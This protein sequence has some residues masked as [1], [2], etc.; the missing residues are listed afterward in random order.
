MIVPSCQAHKIHDYKIHETSFNSLRLIS[1]QGEYGSLSYSYDAVGNRT[2][3]SALTF[4]YNS[5]N[6]LF[7]I[8]DGMVFAYDENENIVTKSNGT[9]TWEYIY[10]TRNGLVKTQKNL[11]LAN[12]CFNSIVLQWLHLYAS[13]YY[14]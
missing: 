12:Q 3:L 14:P 13:V 1:A 4:M 10:Y 8:S 6:E 7:S 2:S 11:M 9:E 5:M